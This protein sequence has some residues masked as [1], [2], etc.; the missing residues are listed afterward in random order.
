MCWLKFVWK[1]IVWGSYSVHKFVFLFQ[2]TEFYTGPITRLETGWFQNLPSNRYILSPPNNFIFNFYDKMYIFKIIWKKKLYLQ[3]K[4]FRFFNC[5]WIFKCSKCT[6]KFFIQKYINCITISCK[7][8]KI[9]GKEKHFLRLRKIK[10]S[11]MSRSPHVLVQLLN[12][13]RDILKAMIPTE[14]GNKHM[15]FKEVDN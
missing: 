13:V 8:L 7:I 1:K 10:S 9:K 5:F 12:H 3:E 4:Y 2:V 14:N 15:L 6:K 11:C